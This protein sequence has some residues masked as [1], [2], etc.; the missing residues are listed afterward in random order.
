MKLKNTVYAKGLEN[1]VSFLGIKNNV[2]QLMQ[3]FDAFIFPSF[4]E[5]LGMV[6]IEAQ[7]AGLPTYC[8]DGVP[9]SVDI[10][11]LI[12]HIPLSSSVNFWKK[13][14]REKKLVLKEMTCI[15]K[16]CDMGYDINSNSV[17]LVNL[18]LKNI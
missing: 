7:A 10:T 9:N 5:G 11:D 4:F 1:K 17:N 14:N 8:S 2:S 16:I 18:Y 13:R 12:V 3:A 15:E 6:A